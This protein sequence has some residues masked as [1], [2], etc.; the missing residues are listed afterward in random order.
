[1]TKKIC[2]ILILSIATY[3]WSEEVAL[4]L[5]SLPKNAI[6]GPT[7]FASKGSHSAGT[8]SLIKQSDKNFI[9]T[10]HH[11]F[12]PEG[13]LPKKM[14]HADI[15]DF[16]KK[17]SIKSLSGGQGSTYPVLKTIPVP[18]LQATSIEKQDLAVF[19]V[20]GDAS[21]GMELSESMPA[22]GESLWLLARVRGG[23]PE[24]QIHHLCKVDRI[25][26]KIVA[27]FENDKIITSG[28]SGAP[29]VNASGKIVGVYSGH[30]DYKGKVYA[31]MVPVD[32]IRKVIE[33][34]E[35]ASQAP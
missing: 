32:V 4:D 6:G 11:L 25:D 1:M 8:A 33:D 17:I 29:V 7:F 14:T 15:Q 35:K 2:Q 21:M 24:G 28:A 30:S 10:S 20:E 9:I 27:I 13:G 3:C 12:G 26:E 23:A 31:F 5:D 19:E 16:V 22:I 18:E 34:S